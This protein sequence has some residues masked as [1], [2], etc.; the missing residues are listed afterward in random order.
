MPQFPKP[1]PHLGMK[2]GF[3]SLTFNSLKTRCLE[4]AIRHP[5]QSRK[6]KAL[7]G[8]NSSCHHIIAPS[9]CN[10]VTWH[11]LTFSK[12][13]SNLFRTRVFASGIHLHFV[14]TAFLQSELHC[15]WWPVLVG[16]RGDFPLL[17]AAQPGL[18]LAA[19]LQPHSSDWAASCKTSTPADCYSIIL[20]VI[21]KN[22]V[23]AMVI[24]LVYKKHGMCILEFS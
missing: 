12:G 5:W 6:R 23:T 19:C 9:S 14:C 2:A 11:S 3:T 1:V 22:E 18:G 13:W 7:P 20:D 21:Q 4:K 24:L 15:F 8:S 16:P 17:W 10:T